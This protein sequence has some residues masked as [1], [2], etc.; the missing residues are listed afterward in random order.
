MDI[1]KKI[2]AEKKPQNLSKISGKLKNRLLNLGFL[3]S[4]SCIFYL[5]MRRNLNISTNYILDRQ[6]LLEL[7]TALFS[8]IH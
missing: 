5:K 8:L 2:K 1:L 6:A 4:K 3:K 7:K